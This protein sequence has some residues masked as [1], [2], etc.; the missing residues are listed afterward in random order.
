MPTT[1]HHLALKPTTLF[2][3]Y[4]IIF[5]GSAGF[6]ITIPAYVSLFLTDHS[7]AIAQNMPIEQRRT[8]FG[9]VMS[10]APFISMFFT[11]F[12]ARFADRFSRKVTMVLCLIIAAIGFAMPIYAIVIGSIALL[13]A[14]NMINSLGSASQPIAQAILADNSRGK[15]KATL[16][17]MVAIV[18]TA[19]MSFGPALGSKLSATYGTQAPFYACFIIAIFCLILLNLVRL[20][21]QVTL[22]N[23]NPL[24]FVAPLKR[25]QSGLLAC[26][27]IVFICQFSWSLY[28]QN[29]AFI[30]P[31]KWG[32]SVESSFYQYFMMAIG[33]VMICSLLLLPRLILARINVLSALRITTLFAAIGMILLAITPTPNT[34]IAA[35][36]FTAI[37]VA[38]AFPFYIT[39]LS[40]RAS[41]ADQGWVMAMSSAMVGLAW[42][43]SGYLTSVFVNIDLILPTAI[44]A[45]GYVIAMIIVPKKAATLITAAN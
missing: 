2:T 27:A 3:L 35:M 5:L 24:S 28:F 10:A 44:A 30:F 17:S 11:P 9:T 33:V 41:E 8:L 7:L 1:T 15:T 6:F 31:Q 25:S 22:H 29:I 38:I 14:G 40:D 32:I 18:M 16:M 21:P 34:H 37:M 23:E 13:F 20:P 45:V 36:I 12:I 39:A 26:L 19:A 4:C 43:L 42:T